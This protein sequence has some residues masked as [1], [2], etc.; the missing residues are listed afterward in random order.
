MG[1]VLLV[2]LVAAVVVTGLVRAGR[3][4]AQAEKPREGWLGGA[5][6]LQVSFA[7]A[8]GKLAQL[9]A[10]QER[11]STVVHFGPPAFLRMAARAND[12]QEPDP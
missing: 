5:E 12:T 1:T 9:G 7:G 10:Q 2:A 8:E 6:G 4:E 3:R 11:G